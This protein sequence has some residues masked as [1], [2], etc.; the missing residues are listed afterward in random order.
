[1][2]YDTPNMRSRSRYCSDKVMIESE[3]L[4]HTPTPHP[5]EDE[6]QPDV[7]QPPVPPDQQPDIVPVEE[8]PKPERERAPMIVL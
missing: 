6:E 8:P 5:Q 7:K 3:Y 1:M 4:M 2:A